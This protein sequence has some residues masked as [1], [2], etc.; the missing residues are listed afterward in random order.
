MKNNVAYVVVAAWPANSDNV[1]IWR[2]GVFDSAG[3]AIDEFESY[4]ED[5]HD[6][7]D[8]PGFICV[9]RVTPI[10]VQ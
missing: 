5:W 2:G 1:Q 9:Q 4:R 8:A 10:F 3:Q 6:I 7:D